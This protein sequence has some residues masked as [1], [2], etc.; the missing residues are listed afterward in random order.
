M[1][2]AG[3]KYS[4]KYEWVRT[5]MY[6]GVEHEVMPA[7][8]ALS[9]VQCHESLKGE[10]TCN[11][12]HQ[13][14]R[15]VDFKKI[16]HKGTDFSY[17]AVQGPRRKP[18]GGHHGLYRLQGPGVQGRSDHLRRTLQ[19][20]A[21]GVQS[22]KIIR[23]SDSSSTV[24]LFLIKDYRPM[25]GIWG[26]IFLGAIRRRA[27]IVRFDIGSLFNLKFKGQIPDRHFFQQTL[28]KGE[29]RGRSLPI[30]WDNDSPQRMYL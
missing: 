29:Y 3:M 8:M 24:R 15:N 6:W 22:R 4:G 26:G 9:C 18:P 13:D 20:A 25:S 23:R 1:K 27:R 14:S 30:L 12:C 21:H 5:N 16:A 11:R 17:M 2:A 28:G 7:D 19:K 10:R